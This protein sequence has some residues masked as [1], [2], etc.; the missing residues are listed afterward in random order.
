MQSGGHVHVIDLITMMR[1]TLEDQEPIADHLIMQLYGEKFYTLSQAQEISKY[2]LRLSVDKVI[3]AMQE[4][5]LTVEEVFHKM[6]KNKRG[7]LNRHELISGLVTGFKQIISE[8]EVNILLEYLDDDGN[9]INH[10]LFNL[11]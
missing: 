4:N 10:F 3:Y 5:N 6:D 8:K 7:M 1:K 2:K 9:G 11:L